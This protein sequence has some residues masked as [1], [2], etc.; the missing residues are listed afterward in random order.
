MLQDQSPWL[1]A[2]PKL[3]PNRASSGVSGGML[4]DAAEAS[5]GVQAAA[6]VPHGMPSDYATIIS[7]WIKDKMLC[8]V[9]LAWTTRFL[10]CG[11]SGLVILLLGQLQLLMTPPL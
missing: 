1:V 2:V 10:G 8:Q 6:S 3:Q 11:W 5:S 9:W 4:K 7:R